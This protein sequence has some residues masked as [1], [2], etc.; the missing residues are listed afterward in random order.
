MELQNS[1]NRLIGAALERFEDERFLRGKGMYVADLVR[2]GMLQAVIV[3]SA[4]AHGKIRSIDTAAARA[5]P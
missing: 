5:W 4:V 1:G 3:R 2:P